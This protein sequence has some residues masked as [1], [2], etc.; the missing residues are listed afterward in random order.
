MKQKLKFKWD[1]SGNKS[2][3]VKFTNG[4]VYQV[5]NSK[6]HENFRVDI[7]EN[8]IQVSVENTSN[9]TFQDLVDINKPIETQMLDWASNFIVKN[10]EVC[11]SCKET[12]ITQTLSKYDLGKEEFYNLINLCKNCRDKIYNKIYEKDRAK[13][14]AEHELAQMEM[15]KNPPKIIGGFK[16]KIDAF[17]AIQKLG[18]PDREIID[19]GFE[20]VK[21]IIKV[22]DGTFYPAFLTICVIDGGEH[23]DTDF[24]ASNLDYNISQELALKYIGKTDKEMFPYE[25][26]TLAHIE[27]DFHQKSWFGTITHTNIRHH[28]INQITLQRPKNWEDIEATTKVQVRSYFSIQHILSAAYL[29]KQLIKFEKTISH[30]N[31]NDDDLID[32][33]SLAV[34]TILCCTSF[35]E[36]NINELFM[37]ASENPNGI[38]KDLPK[39]TI[40][41]LSKMWNRGIPRTASYPILEK[42]QIALAL[43]NKKEFDLGTL[44]IQNITAL[45]KLRNALIHYEPE[46][47]ITKDITQ[48]NSIVKKQRLE[49]QLKGKFKLNPYTGID[50]P[51]FPDKCLSL[52]CAL[53]ALNSSINFTDEFFMKLGIVPTYQRIKHK[54]IETMMYNN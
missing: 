34:S 6:F 38:I 41:R 40:K 2:N 46:S 29:S 52:G 7:L 23:W 49:Q 30:E 3:L 27:G 28:F 44:L 31:N 42:Y 20:Y 21:S 36:A 48:E 26:E 37:D 50:N 11:D 8:E 45:I 53:W 25:Y 32:Y 17:K 1:E 54:F 10:I 18:N 9:S 51:F 12:K 14:L 13:R 4:K 19:E 35:L 22:A 5:I 39:S 15:D 33:R 16:R 47:V 43:S 24:I